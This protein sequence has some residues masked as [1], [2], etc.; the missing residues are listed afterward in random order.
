MEDNQ[1]LFPISVDV[2]YDGMV[3]DYSIYYYMNNKPVLLCKDVVLTQAMIK[4]FKNDIK[5]RKNVNM[6]KQA[7]ARVLNESVYF[8]QAQKQI[9][10]SIGY[11]AIKDNVRNMLASVAV[12]GK[13]IPEEVESY[14][15]TIAQQVLSADDSLIVQCLN[16]VR[17]ADEYLYTHSTN[18]GVLNGLIGRWLSLV[19]EDIQKLIKIGLLHDLGKLR[20]S[21]KILNK[22]G[23]L[24][25]AEFEE[26]KKHAVFSYKILESSGEQDEQILEA[27]LHHHEKMNGT[28]YPDRLHA[29]QIS[30]FA[31]ITSVSDVYDAMVAKRVYKNSNSPFEILQ[32]LSEG[33]FSYLDRNIVNVFLKY[34]PQ[35]LSGKYC[36]L[37]NGAVAKIKLISPRNLRYPIVALDDEIIPTDEELFCVC[38]CPDTVAD[39][40]GS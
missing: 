1:K 23:A 13:I 4:H 21:E 5:G 9:E 25:N 28:G 20:I 26:M 6:N 18:V 17:R 2:L 16:N 30:L 12:S 39:E 37:N 27:V 35:H 22:P 10:D 31:R 36:I 33:S 3:V 8:K 14:Q 40:S 15:A 7:H 38:M 11:T 29:A 24:T 19:K 34:M 32:Q